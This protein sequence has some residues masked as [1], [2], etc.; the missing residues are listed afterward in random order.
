MDDLSTLLTILFYVA[1][2]TAG[3]ASIFA[4]FRSRYIKST[5]EELRSDRDDLQKRVDRIET[6]RDE[7][8][9][10]NQHRDDLIKQQTDQIAALKEA[11]SGKAQLNHLQE[12]LD[13]HDKRVDD[14]HAEVNK[15]IRFMTDTLLHIDKVVSAA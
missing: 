9:K 12:Q 4:L 14:R 11:L 5:L 6:E 13:A 2:A 8:I 1:M 15:K 7:A 10:G 3:A